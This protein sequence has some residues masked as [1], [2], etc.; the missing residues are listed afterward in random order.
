MFNDILGITKPLSDMLQSSHIDLASVID[1]V[2]SVEKTVTEHCCRGYFQKIW[3]C[4]LKHV[5]N[6]NVDISSLQEKQKSVVPSRLEALILA[7]LE[8]WSMHDVTARPLIKQ[9]SL[10]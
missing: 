9:C 3:L 4:V 1:L 5:E 6:N 7:T 2:D 10:K 8:R